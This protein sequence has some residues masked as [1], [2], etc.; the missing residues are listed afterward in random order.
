[1]LFKT[2]PTSLIASNVYSV[3]TRIVNFYIYK[4]EKFAICID[5]GFGVS[6]IKKEMKKIKI[7]PE[8][9]THI[10]LTHTD[11]DHTDGIKIFSKAGTS[12]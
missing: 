6:K 7:A 4:Q 3:N 2:T 10:F 8:D 1:M 12:I 11:K 9:I 5:T